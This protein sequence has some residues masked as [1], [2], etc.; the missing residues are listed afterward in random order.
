MSPENIQERRRIRERR[1]KKQ[2]RLFPPQQ[3]IKTEDRIRRFAL[4]SWERTE[5][6]I[7]LR[8]HN[9]EDQYVLSFKHR[10]VLR[11]FF[12]A[13]IAIAT[14]GDRKLYEGFMEKYGENEGLI[15]SLTPHFKLIR[16]FI[17]PPHPK[18]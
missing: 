3:V 14:G 18:R 15:L 6:L 16:D 17:A 10:G 1:R 9:N 4:P 2:E 7:E 11:E 13:R 12:D 8:M 5:R